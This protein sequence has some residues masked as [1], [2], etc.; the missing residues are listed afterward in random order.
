MLDDARDDLLR[1]DG[2]PKAFAAVRAIDDHFG[3]HILVNDGAA[4]GTLWH[5]GACNV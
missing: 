1:L 3:S 4:R 5:V 2:L